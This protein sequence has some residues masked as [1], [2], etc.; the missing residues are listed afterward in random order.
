LL[1]LGTPVAFGRLHVAKL[2]SVE[3]GSQQSHLAVA[4]RRSNA[5]LPGQRNAA[6]LPLSCGFT[7]EIERTMVAAEKVRTGTR[8]VLTALLLFVLRP[9]LAY[10][11]ADAIKAR[12]DNFHVLSEQMKAIVQ[13]LGDGLPVS[14]M[15]DHVAVADQAL[16]RVPRMFPPGSDKG[17]TKAL[18]TIWAEPDHFK[19]TY[20]AA[21]V[22][23]KALV[24][25]AAQSDRSE[26]GAAVGQMAAACGD[27]HAAFRAK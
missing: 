7:A 9:E 12:K 23:M 8:L 27:C 1:R 25:A 15:Q 21:L 26:F 5:Q 18:P 24:A 2:C 6:K 11:Q 17:D 14:A 4:Y 16:Q 20:G 13:G 10:P 19:A 22:R 3:P